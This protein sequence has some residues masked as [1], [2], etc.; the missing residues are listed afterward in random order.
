MEYLSEPV[1]LSFS[2]VIFGDN[3]RGQ[4]HVTDEGYTLEL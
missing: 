3:S 4:N 1:I 2:R